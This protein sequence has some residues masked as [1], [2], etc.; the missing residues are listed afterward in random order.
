MRRPFSVCRARTL[1]YGRRTS[2]DF[3][4][5]DAPGQAIVGV[6]DQVGGFR[7]MGA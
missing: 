2:Y 4:Y 7:P 1:W 5:T 6:V 3:Y